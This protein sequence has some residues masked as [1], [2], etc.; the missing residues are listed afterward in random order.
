MQ[1]DGKQMHDI[2]NLSKVNAILLRTAERQQI[3]EFFLI[4]RSFL[5]LNSLGTYNIHLKTFG[6]SST[7][8]QLEKGKLLV[9]TRDILGSIYLEAFVSDI[10]YPIEQQEINIAKAEYSQS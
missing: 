4:A 1:N 7:D 5:Q 9:Q 8:K 3:W 10:C 2:L 6:N